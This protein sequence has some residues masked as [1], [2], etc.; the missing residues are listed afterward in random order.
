[1]QVQ[2][3]GRGARRWVAFGA[4]AFGAVFLVVG[5][6]LAGMSVSFLVDAERAPGTVVALEWRDDD[7][8]ASRRK[9][10]NDEPVAYPVVE[11]TSADGT[12]RTFRSSTGSNPPSYEEGERVEVLY[13][14]DSPEDA[15]INGFASLW[16]LPLVFGGIG[17]VIAGVGTAVATVGRRRSQAVPTG[18][19]W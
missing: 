6:I 15:R 16:L 8:G 18:G 2:V 13:R 4:I 12:S 7:N 19:R 9:R 17:L 3:R 10:A 5:L 11:F 1:M 14:A